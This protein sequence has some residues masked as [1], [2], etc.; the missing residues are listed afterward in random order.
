MAFLYIREMK[1]L[2]KVNRK[3]PASRQLKNLTQKPT[4]KVT[5][6][7]IE[8]FSFNTVGFYFI[9]SRETN[10]LLKNVATRSIRKCERVFRRES[11]HH[12]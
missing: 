4:K 8:N 6:K 7:S 5:G 9:D 3:T 2:F 12:I 1:E 11:M 10:F